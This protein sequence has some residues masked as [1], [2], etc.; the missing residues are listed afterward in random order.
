MKT[1]DVEV[2]AVGTWN[3]LEFNE[4]DLKLIVN[5]F[6]NLKEYHD[7]PIKFGH[8]KE[9]SMTDGQ[10][11]L[12]WVDKLWLNG[13][14]L[15]ST[16]IDVPDIVAEAFEKK[17]Y[18]K[19]SIE[20]DMGVEHK[21]TYYPWVLS[22]LELLGADIPAVNVLADLQAYMGRKDMSLKKR[23][24][25]SKNMDITDNH[26]EDNL[27]DPEMIQ[28]K[29]QI[30]TLEMEKTALR[31]ENEKLVQKNADLEKSQVKMKADYRSIED[32][33]AL[34]KSNERRGLLESRLEGMVKAAKI[35]PFSRDGYL[36]DFDGAPDE[37]TRKSIIYAVESLEKTID[38]NPA[39]FGAEQARSKADRKKNESE[40]SAAEIVT[41]RTNE[42]MAKHG[43]KSFA[44]AKT[45]VLCADMDLANRYTKMED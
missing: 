32:A 13:T 20:L 12:G 42:Y 26:K 31:S 14:K 3:G 27:M 11:A 16:L 37:E 9:Q 44:K 19:V 45:A 33:E 38:S 17:L 10:P 30:N 4:E 7:V 15:M 22:G 35:A 23:V 28:L 40:K 5:A 43:E 6:S 1:L 36:T 39:Y 24:F 18:K 34:R 25:F 2:F 41:E 21:G 29:E 8:N